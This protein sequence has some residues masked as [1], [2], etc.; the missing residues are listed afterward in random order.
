MIIRLARHAVLVL[1]L[2]AA[3]AALAADAVDPSVAKRHVNLAQL[4][5]MLAEQIAKAACFARLGVNAAAQ[6]QYLRGARELFVLTQQGL[7]EG[8]AALGLEPETHPNLIQAL[9]AFDRGAGHWVAQTGAVAA[10]NGVLSAQAFDALL[11]A[12]GPVTRLTEDFAGRAARTYGA[13]EGVPLSLSVRIEV[14]SRQRLLSQRIA[15]EFCLIASGRES[16][17]RRA[18]LGEAIAVFDQSLTA[19]I[20]GVEA[21]G[22]P[23]ETDP[24]RLSRL[25]GVRAAWADMKPVV[26]AA[27]AG[28]APDAAGIAEVAWSNNVILT[29]ANATVFAYETDEIGG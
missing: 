11:L 6:M 29:Q 24:G 18:A 5:P 9:D 3:P 23:A 12:T 4:Q 27:A 21:F 10:S 1:A 13:T 28:A 2:G 20:E 7:R 22:L 8:N 17:E 25:E 19:L 26:E 16:A 14:A 15:K